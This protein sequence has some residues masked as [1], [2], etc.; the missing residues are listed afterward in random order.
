MESKFGR[1]VSDGLGKPLRMI[2]RIPRLLAADHVGIIGSD[3]TVV[4]IQIVS[5]LGRSG[6][7][8][9]IDKTEKA[10]WIVVGILPHFGID[11]SE[12]TVGIDG[13]GPPKVIGKVSQPPEAPWQVKAIERADVK[14]LA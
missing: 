9:A 11:A 5:I 4:E 7:A 8:I 12:H 14:P 10:N 3:N 6:Q 1:E 13:P 2:L